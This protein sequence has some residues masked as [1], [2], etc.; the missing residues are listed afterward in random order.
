MKRNTKISF[1]VFASVIFCATCTY[2]ANDPNVCFAENILPIFV[3]NC[4]GCHGSGSGIDLTNYDGIMRGVVR[5]H[6]LRSKVYNYIKGSNPKM[7]PASHKQLTSEQV[8]TIKAWISMGAPN[9][10]N[11][12]GCDTSQYKFAA[13]IQPI[14]NNWCVACHT[15]GNAGGGHDLSN[16]TGVANCVGSGKFLGSIKHSPGY[17]PMPQNSPQLSPCD[18]IKI[19]N[20]VNAGYHNN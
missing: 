17:I 14:L 10:S 16:Y 7:P 2:R 8:F 15:S 3:S 9:S 19:Q 11:C 1:L 20:W 13:N 5:H 4:A 6:P 12:S 18:I